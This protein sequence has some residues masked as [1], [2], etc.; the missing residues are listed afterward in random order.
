[1]NRIFWL[2]FFDETRPLGEGFLGV[3]IIK[4][5]KE[6]MEEVKPRIL[7]QYPKAKEEAFWIGAAIERSWRMGCN[8]GGQVG[9]CEIMSKDIP[10]HITLLYDKL[11]SKEDLKKNNL[12]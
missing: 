11:L 3:A 7:A 10:L 6:D 4:V 12:I 1:M 8:P 2:D 9:F 5:S